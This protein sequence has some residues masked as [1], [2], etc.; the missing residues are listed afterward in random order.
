MAWLLP[1]WLLLLALCDGSGRYASKLKQRQRQVR[2]SPTSSA[3]TTMLTSSLGQAQAM[4]SHM[5]AAPA[6]SHSVPAVPL[7]AFVFDQFYDPDNAVLTDFIDAQLLQQ[8]NDPYSHGRIL[9]RRGRRRE[10]LCCWLL[11]VWLIEPSSVTA[12][13]Y[14]VV[15]I[16]LLMT[17]CCVG[18][19]LAFHGIVLM[20]QNHRDGLLS[21]R[22]AGYHDAIPLAEASHWA[23]APE[24]LISDAIRWILYPLLWIGSAGWLTACVHLWRNGR[25]ALRTLPRLWVVHG[26]YAARA[27]SAPML[28]AGVDFLDSLHML[29]CLLIILVVTLLLELTTYSFRSFFG[30][31]PGPA[32]LMQLPH[33]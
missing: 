23:L 17:S 7:E 29:M 30:P 22:G 12:L 24:E 21:Q 10:A 2:G 1:V 31:A 25:L 18:L 32:E 13:L 27:Q 16:G 20:Q 14:S 15:A 11:S 6:L 5:D 3:P 4:S 26:E 19:Y 33:S 8:A 9:W 28:T